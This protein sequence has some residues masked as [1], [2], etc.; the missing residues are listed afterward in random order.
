MKKTNLNLVKDFNKQLNLMTDLNISIYN[1]YKY[2]K[3]QYIE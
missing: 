3:I 1:K 2:L